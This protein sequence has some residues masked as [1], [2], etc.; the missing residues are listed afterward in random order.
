MSERPVP[1][2]QMTTED[3]NKECRPYD[4]NRAATGRRCP[5]CTMQVILHCNDCKIQI[6]GCLCTEERNHGPEIARQRMIDRGIWLP[7][8]DKDPAK[9]RL[10]ANRPVDPGKLHG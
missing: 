2:P 10:D 6:T 4:P 8:F 1:Y 9:Y 5:V 7:E 3:A